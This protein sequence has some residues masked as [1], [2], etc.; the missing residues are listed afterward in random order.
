M[1]KPEP[2]ITSKCGTYAG[3]SYHRRYKEQ[4]CQP[5]RDAM[6]ERRR[7]LWEQSPEKYRQHGVRHKE[8]TK[9]IREAEKQ[10]KKDAREA[11]KAE[12]EI[13]KSEE[14]LAASRL[15]E[16]NRATAC[17]DKVS[18]K[19]WN[20]LNKKPKKANKGTSNLSWIESGKKNFAEANAKRKIASDARKAVHRQEQERKRLIKRLIKAMNKRVKHLRAQEARSRENRHGVSIGDYTRCKKQNGTACVDCRKAAADYMRPRNRANQKKGTHGNPATRRAAHSRAARR[21]RARIRNAGYDYYTI[22]QVLDT[23]GTDCHICGTPIDL[24]HSRNPLDPGWLESL[25]IDHYVPISKGGP[26]TLA[27]VRPAHGKCNIRK[28]ATLP[29]SAIA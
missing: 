1:N 20:L 3:W 9:P 14:R 5:C 18:K 11:A 23:Y 28:G 21:R 27:N 8:K 13:K 16:Y 2:T 10:E 26:D 24:M 29:D 12:K 7:Q 4:S 19:L 6:N 25:H 17:L 15:A 22:E